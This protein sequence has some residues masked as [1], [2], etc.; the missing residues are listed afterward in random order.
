MAMTIPVLKARGKRGPPRTSNCRVAY[1]G[2]PYGNK[3]NCWNPLKPCTP[4]H[5][6]EINSCVTVAK[7]EKSAWMAQ[8][9]SLNAETMG[10]QQPSPE[11]GKVQRLSFAGVGPSGPKWFAPLQ[12][13]ED[14]VCA[15]VKAWGV[16]LS[17]KRWNRAGFALRCDRFSDETAYGGRRCCADRYAAHP[18]AGEPVRL[19]GHNQC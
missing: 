10:N 3:L 15:H 9:A 8:G 7:A 4:Q 16:R 17:D 13:G 1:G 19:R 18:P 6:N 12:A 5:R 11:Q 2:S 14:I